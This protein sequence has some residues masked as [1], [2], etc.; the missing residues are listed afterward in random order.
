MALSRVDGLEFRPDEMKLFDHRH[1][2]VNSNEVPMPASMASNSETTLNG[3][4]Q[5]RR[6]TLN[7]T[8][9]NFF[10]LKSYLSERELRNAAITEQLLADDKNYVLSEHE[11]PSDLIL[12]HQRNLAAKNASI[13]HHGHK[14]SKAEIEE[15]L[16]LAQEVNELLVQK[17]IEKSKLAR[18]PQGKNRR[19]RNSLLESQWSLDGSY[20][21]KSVAGSDRTQGSRRGSMMD[22]EFIINDAYRH[23][24][25]EDKKEKLRLQ[26]Q[27][28]Q[29]SPKLKSR[30]SSGD[31]AHSLDDAPRFEQPS[32]PSP[33][34]A[35]EEGGEGEEEEEEEE[36]EEANAFISEHNVELA[37]PIS[38]SKRGSFR[39]QLGSARGSNNHL[40]RSSSEM[41]QSRRNVAR[42]ISSQMEMMDG[43]E[44]KTLLMS[45][46]MFADLPLNELGRLSKSLETVEFAD[47]E[48]IIQ[49]GDRNADKFY[50]IKAGQVE[51]KKTVDGQTQIMG[52]MSEGQ[53]FGERALLVDE[54]RAA[55]CQADGK[56]TCLY[57][58]RHDF[59]EI[60]GGTRVLIDSNYRPGRGKDPDAEGLSNHVNKFA[61]YL[62]RCE[63]A[64]ESRDK[65]QVIEAGVCL[66]LHKI[67]SPELR[68]RD[69]IE[70]TIKVIYELFDVDRVGLFLI[71]LTQNKMILTVS[72]NARNIVM[73]ISG[74]AGEAAKS[75][76][77]ENIHDVSSDP[78]FDP[79]MDKK[80]GYGTRCM[81]C[82]PLKHP[83]TGEVIAVLQLI[84]KKTEEESYQEELENLQWGLGKH[85]GSDD[86]HF[87][88][89]VDSLAKMR[90][91][92]R[93]SK[94]LETL[95]EINAEEQTK[96]SKTS[97][98][99][100]RTAGGKGRGG[101]TIRGSTISSARMR[102]LQSLDEIEMEWPTFT[103][104]DVHLLE[105]I[106]EQLSSMLA[107]ALSRNTNEFESL[108]KLH[109]PISCKVISAHHLRKFVRTGPKDK[110]TGLR[111]GPVER[112]VIP[113]GKK[114][115]VTLSVYH[116]ENQLGKSCETQVSTLFEDS[117][118]EWSEGFGS[119]THQCYLSSLPRATRFIF[120]VHKPGKGP[121]GTGR[122][123][124]WAG[125]S[126]ID[127]RDA[128]VT[129]DLSLRLW[130]G[131]CASPTVP[132][133]QPIEEKQSAGMLNIQFPTY[134]KEVRFYCKEDENLVDSLGSESQKEEQKR[135]SKIMDL[136]AF[137]GTQISV[138]SK[139][140][141]VINLSFLAKLTTEQKD[142]VWKHRKL[143]TNYPRALPKLLLSVRW[144]VPDDV[145]EVHTLLY[146]W[147][148]MDPV[149]ALQLLDSRFPDPKIRAY[150]VHLLDD[151]TDQGLRPYLL[152]LVQCLKH[153]SYHDSALARFLV[154]RAISNPDVIGHILYW[155]LKSEVHIDVV[156]DRFSLILGE[157]LR[158]VEPASRTEL[159]HQGFVM[160]RLVKIAKSI[161][162]TKGKKQQKT[163][164]HKELR[165]L[166]LPHTFQLPLSPDVICDGIHINECRVMDSKKKPLWI[167]FSAIEYTAVQS[168]TAKRVGEMDGLQRFKFPVLFKAGDDL[169]Q[170]QLT[171]QLLSIMDSI[172]KENGLNLEL[173]PYA[174]VATGDQIG[175]LEVVQHSTTLASVVK[176]DT[177][178]NRGDSGFVARFKAAKKAISNKDY[179]KVWLS[180]QAE[181][182]AQSGKILNP[183]L[184]NQRLHESETDR[185]QPN[186]HSVEDIERR[187]KR[188]FM[189]SCAGYCV[190]TFVLG[191]GDRHNDNLMISKGGRFFHI[192]FGHF[193]GNFKSKYGVKRE[194][195]PFVFTN[196]MAEALGGTNSALF[197]EFEETCG[198]A[199]NVMRT[200]G[201][202][203][204]SL[205]RLMISCGIPELERE[206]DI[207]YLETQLM[208]GLSDAE[209]TEEFKKEIEKSMH[210]ATTRYNDAVSICLYPFSLSFGEILM[211][212]SYLSN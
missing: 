171:L 93:K 72:S 127:F 194:R 117:N 207:L 52:Y 155:L 89:K 179:L 34:P 19:H 84:N 149:D 77:L 88:K 189:K 71:D 198:R 28:S 121:D 62:H 145:Q 119:L 107:K 41:T 91:N 188:S 202:L 118:A 4:V 210:T 172:W 163:L 15:E 36:E 61:E 176:E 147:R 103:S 153:E 175:F 59:E 178:L 50:I 142:L 45:I 85:M 11:M 110:E 37:S 82:C 29:F 40:R 139:L 180:K 151:L 99:G 160:R 106:S 55:T 69:I 183:I 111:I 140:E 48:I 131:G 6:D 159:G 211:K 115:L 195:A 47:G 96:I 17:R 190:A 138:N 137:R 165:K 205:F 14:D 92:R 98:R 94:M 203:L 105:K 23:E 144:D 150:A 123:V 184:L 90:K 193:L 16:I 81:I 141:S 5:R 156:R 86:A 75:G 78:R 209:A 74:L 73:P 44:E 199:L 64:E 24:K 116:G 101:R 76:N 13:E 80:T 54:P 49:E 58:L 200:K 60:L 122:S 186:L 162:H 66:A 197:H 43:D 126:A 120:T 113:K 185:L 212:F 134:E 26:A 38:P 148:R 3:L 204:I 20:P 170:D 1:S 7:R 51:I 25:E 182:F 114:M 158:V 168:G 83:E 161:G 208:P 187:M 136:S 196:A 104:D 129:G 169:R 146:L 191:I 135:K 30:A 18:S 143:L 181:Q 173:A 70:C 2:Q 128:L 32:K 35:A 112:L 192:D 95:K 33:F 154:C 167:V 8:M 57:L 46:P 53:T 87:Q 133:L 157:Y 177:A 10:D 65:L 9:S 22:L 152:Q 27:T 21:A 102:T 79:Q 12:A 130:P 108:S 31:G 124:G 67:F 56:V 63:E 125:M 109:K 100:G 174:C 132:N 68:S 164:L 39:G 206:E 166:S 201:D 97:R 42:R